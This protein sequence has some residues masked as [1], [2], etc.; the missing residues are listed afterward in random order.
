MVLYIAEFI[1]YSAHK[2]PL[3]ALWYG[4]FMVRLL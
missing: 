2:M 1:Y 3:A 4:G